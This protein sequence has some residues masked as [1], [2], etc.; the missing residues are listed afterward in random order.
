[1]EQFRLID[2][3]DVSLQVTLG[4]LLADRGIMGPI[5]SI[6]LLLAMVDVR[7]A[8]ANDRHGDAR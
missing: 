1:M 8:V 7:T 2:R 5:R 4:A 3:A 6:G